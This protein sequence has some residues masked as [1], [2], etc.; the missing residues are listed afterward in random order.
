M[1][2]KWLVIPLSLT[3]A[4]IALA[5]EDVE[6]L[7]VKARMIAMTTIVE[8][9]PTLGEMAKGAVDFDLEQAKVGLVD[10]ADK[11]KN[12]PELFKSD[13]MHPRSEAL[14]V[15]WTNF[16]DFTAKS[17]ALTD[18]ATKALANFSSQDD[19]IPSMR[20]LGSTCKSCHS[21]YRK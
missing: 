2:F 4:T 14:P 17:E 18:A 8:N 15:I 6:N 7:T 5:H 1:N 21:T 13:E 12:V 19:L 20:A 16:D 11:A 10:I 9:M 3:T